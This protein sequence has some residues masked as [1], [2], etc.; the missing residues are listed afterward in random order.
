MPTAFKTRKWFDA[1]VKYT[2][3]QVRLLN[4]SK[5]FAGLMV[6]TIN[7][8]SKFVKFKFS[9]SIDNYLKH[10]FS[11]DIL[12]FCI[13]WMGCR[14]IYIALATTVGFMICAEFLFNEHSTFCIL[15]ESFVQYH[16][17]APEPSDDE[18]NMAKDV[19]RRKEEFSRERRSS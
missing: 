1:L 19:L 4:G 6:M 13:V 16:Q 10:T 15:P 2:D 12:V 7:I 17:E 5:I 14:D 3:A 18:V 9:P 8:A 11:R